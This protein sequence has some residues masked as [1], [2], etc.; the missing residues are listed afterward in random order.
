MLDSPGQC[1]TCR[2]HHRPLNILK[3]TVWDAHVVAELVLHTP[4]VSDILSQIAIDFSSRLILNR[5]KHA[6]ENI[7]SKPYI[8]IMLK[9]SFIFCISQAKKNWWIFCRKKLPPK[10]KSKIRW[11]YHRKSMDSKLNSTVP[12]LNWRNKQPMKRKLPTNTWRWNFF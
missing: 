10:S 9:I 7:T 6:P 4:M 1:G 12:K 8:I 3:R 11:N 5:A 2:K